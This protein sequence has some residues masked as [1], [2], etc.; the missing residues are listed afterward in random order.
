MQVSAAD[1]LDP[2]YVAQRARRIDR[3]RAQDFGHGVPPRSGTV[4]LT[5]ADSGGMM[6]SYIQSNY[7]GFG[8]GVVVPGTGISLQ[9]RG[10]CF[11]LTPGHPNQ[12]GPRQTPFHTIIPAF[13]TRAGQPLMSFGVMGADMQPQGHMQMMVRARRL[14][15]EP[16]SGRGRRR[17]GRCWAGAASS[18]STT[19][20]MRR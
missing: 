19:C 5:A 13:A 12:V 3:R 14:P 9:N 20:R 4:Y 16:A 17:A 10:A 15:A 7:M 2:G 1:L 11:R 18:S 8:S 6:V